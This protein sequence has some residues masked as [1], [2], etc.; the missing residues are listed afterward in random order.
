MLKKGKIYRVRNYAVSPDAAHQEA[1]EAIV[2]GHGWLWIYD[3]G[4]HLGPSGAPLRY[5]LHSVATGAEQWFEER[6]LEAADA[7]EG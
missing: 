2:E 1:N 7:E 6:E 4:V 5:W 3:N